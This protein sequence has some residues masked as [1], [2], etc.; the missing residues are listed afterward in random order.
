MAKSHPDHVMSERQFSSRN[1][2]AMVIKFYIEDAF[3][4]AVNSASSEIFWLQ[5]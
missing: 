4:R 5:E 3:S 1:T 2:S